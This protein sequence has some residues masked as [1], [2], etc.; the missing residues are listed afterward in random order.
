MKGLLGKYD[1][2]QL[3]FYN[4]YGVH[5]LTIET[6]KSHAKHHTRYSKTPASYLYYDYSV[7]FPIFELLNPASK[8]NWRIVK[9]KKSYSVLIWC[10]TSRSKYRNGLC[11]RKGVFLQ[12]KKC[13]ELIC[14]L[15]TTY[16]WIVFNTT[17]T[18]DKNLR[19]CISFL[20]IIHGG[21]LCKISVF[22]SI[23]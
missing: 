3:A 16:S 20:R 14:S 15:E 21:I 11:H 5:K 17:K 23:F 18:T 1:T 13:S 9:Y 19:T 10:C 22:S 6:H 12:K 2:L 8:Y 7:I 4:V